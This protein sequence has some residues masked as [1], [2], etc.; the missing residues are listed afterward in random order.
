MR[1][2][3]EKSSLFAMRSWNVDVKFGNGIPLVRDDDFLPATNAHWPALSCSRKPCLGVSIFDGR[4]M[5]TFVEVWEIHGAEGKG[6][7]CH[8]GAVGIYG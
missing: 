7:G 5:V 8:D 3:P 6:V 4:N 1:I 2:H